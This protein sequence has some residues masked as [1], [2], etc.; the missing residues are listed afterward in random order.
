MD[1]T[2]EDRVPLRVW[3]NLTIATIGQFHQELTTAVSSLSRVEIE[4]DDDA[5]FDLTLIQLIES[6]RRTASTTEC[7][8]VLTSP[9]SGALLAML[10]R[11]GFVPK[12]A[13][14]SRNF[15][16]HEDMT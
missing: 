4:V 12:G 13:I 15:W 2:N 7:E 3:G 16:L 1:I 10:E 14:E 6:A 5:E 8:L 11:G 9:A